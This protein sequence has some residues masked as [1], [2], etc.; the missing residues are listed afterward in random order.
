[1]THLSHPVP[2]RAVAMAI[3]FL[4]LSGCVPS[5][6]AGIPTPVVQ[7]VNPQTQPLVPGL[8]VT[9]TAQPTASAHMAPTATP[10][11]PSAAAA[12]A[13]PVPPLAPPATAVPPAPA[14][15]TAAPAPSAP[16]G[17]YVYGGGAC[18]TV[19]HVVQRGEN[20]FRIA[21][22]YGATT[23]SVA[24]QNRIANTALIYTGQRLTIT[25]C[26]AGGGDRVYVVQPGDTLYRIAGRFGV[27]VQAI[28][29][30]NRLASAFI[31]SGQVLAIP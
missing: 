21:L 16:A 30:A 8:Q 12:T 19:T 15:P 5:A 27:T 11:P 23:A 25:A 2:W 1:M 10:M 29:L 9:V 18:R 22:R 4:A 14:A 17:D 7:G 6:S 31:V 13:T 20:L 26:G 28:Q 24:R 3:A